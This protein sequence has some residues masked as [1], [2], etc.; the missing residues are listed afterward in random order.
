M[1]TKNIFLF[2]FISALSMTTLFLFSGCRNSSEKSNQQ[3]F[4]YNESNGI[5]SLDPAFSRD[6]EVMWA[7]NQ[8]FDGLV[9][10]DSNMEVIPCIAKRWEISPDG[11]TYT[12]HL[13]DSVYFHPSP[14]FADSS[15]RKVIASDFIYT[16]NRLLDPTVASPAT[17]IFSSVD[18]GSGNAFEAT[19]DSTLL[20]HL[21]RPFQPFL[22]MLS[23][24]YCNVVPHEVV[25]FY[26]ADFR[27]H[28]IG[29]GPFRF[30]FWYENVAL[31]FHKH[32]KYW[33]HDS[34]GNQLPYL[35]AIKID[36]V[37]DMS[38]EFQGLLQGRYDFMSGIHE[39]FKD[40]LLD[41]GGN[42]VE[43]YA[44]DIRFQKTPFIK[45]DYL[46]IFMDPEME[47]NQNSPLMDVR[48]R[49][50][51]S[52]AI[53]KKSMV[54]YLRNNSVFPAVN[55]FLP[56]RLNKF[57]SDSVYYNYDPN[58]AAQLLSEAG[59]PEGKGLPVFSISTTSDYTDLIEYIQHQLEKIGI[60]IKVNVLQQPALREQSAKGQLSIFRKSWLADY[61]DAENFLAVFYS[62]NFC[63]SGPN[64][65]HFSNSDF[66]QLYEKARTLTDDSLRFEAYAK[67]NDIL[68][69]EAP[70]IPLYY[71]QVSHFIRKNIHGLQTNP[72]NML[73]LRTV[74]KE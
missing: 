2:L 37:K 24:Q 22:G 12:F 55:G 34:K 39:S 3:V 66:D 67:L 18:T 11:L 65:T 17:W 47:I 61:A 52:Y 5:T 59:Y 10:L 6:I 71:D 51:I 57:G 42:L 36:F 58:L 35:D 32:E 7:T 26:K 16:F 4:N 62:G 74:R 21:S 30:A 72:V 44:E 15:H 50:A 1:N 53:D 8:L 69:N 20:I 45:T 46:G 48:V 60:I 54:R 33:Q 49:R 9:E 29:T 25:E 31:V 63:P 41:A 40:E 13:R 70:V 27:N 56:P 19:N 64:Y 28:P 43:A 14:L 38:V 23:M 68:M 73:D